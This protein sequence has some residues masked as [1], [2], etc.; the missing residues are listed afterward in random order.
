[1]SWVSRSPHSAWQEVQACAR[2]WKAEQTPIYT[3]HEH[4]RNLIV[5][6]TDSK[7]IRRSDRGRGKEHTPVPRGQI[8]R[9]WHSLAETGQ[10]PVR[11]GS[12]LRLRTPW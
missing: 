6:V 2:R 3:L 4:V 12:P 1:M 9:T 5:D 8:T 7:I 11:R 10:A